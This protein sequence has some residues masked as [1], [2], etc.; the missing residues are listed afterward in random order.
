MLKKVNDLLSKQPLHIFKTISVVT[1]ALSGSGLFLYILGY[2]FM[3]GYYFSSNIDNTPSLME[4]LINPIPF[5]YYSIASISSYLLLCV[6]FFVVLFIE[7]KRKS[8]RNTIALFCKII[9]FYCLFLSGILFTVIVTD[10]GKIRPLVLF[11]YVFVTLLAILITIDLLTSITVELSL[12]PDYW[13]YSYY[14]YPLHSNCP[15][16]L[17]TE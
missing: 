9:F 12:Y 4:L 13:C 7:T 11:P 16:L 14:L 6:S 5:N 17:S 15:P 10:K 3:F 1:I 2:S 8:H